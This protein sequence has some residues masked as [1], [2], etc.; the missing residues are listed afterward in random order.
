[1]SYEPR[2]KAKE[3]GVARGFDALAEPT[4]RLSREKRGCIVI[5]CRRGLMS[6]GI[7]HLATT[8]LARD[9]R[10]WPTRA[11]TSAVV[12]DMAIA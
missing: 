3:R 4:S 12:V 5:S 8:D 11:A 6:C 9:T 7:T 2:R 10:A 1:M